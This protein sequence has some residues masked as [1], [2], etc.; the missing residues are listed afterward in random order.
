MGRLERGVSKY[1]TSKNECLRALIAS[2]TFQLLMSFWGDLFGRA[3][4]IGGTFQVAYV[5]LRSEDAGGGIYFD[6]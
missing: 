4:K 2:Y 1:G 3:C 6:V 5:R